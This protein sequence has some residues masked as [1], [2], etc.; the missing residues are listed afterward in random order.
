MK[1]VTIAGGAALGLLLLA[2]IGL[3]L[4]GMRADAGTLRNTIEI[5]RPP[6]AVWPWLTEPDHL[7]AWIG[8]VVEVRAL[9]PGPHGVGSKSVIVVQDQNN[10]NARMEIQEEVREYVEPRKL[11]TRMMVPGMFDG[12]GTFEIVDLGNGKSRLESHSSFRYDEWWARLLEPLI[13]P[14]ARDK[15]T[16]DLTRLKQ[17]AESAPL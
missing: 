5:A 11:R 6:A 7:K 17:L 10:N 4:A 14:S 3:M 1:W 2:V 8:W 9:T 15:M 16:Q 13:T 12:E